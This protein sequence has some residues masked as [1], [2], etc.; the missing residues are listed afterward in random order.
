MNSLKLLLNQE[1]ISF[2]FGDNM[3]LNDSLNE[4]FQITRSIYKCLTNTLKI[5]I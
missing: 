1:K 3:I 5:N 2:V 4:L